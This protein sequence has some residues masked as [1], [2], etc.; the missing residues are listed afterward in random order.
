MEFEELKNKWKQL[1]EHVKAQDDKI[2]ELT[3]Q[4]IAGKV[5]SPLTVLKR[6]CVIAAVFVPFMLPFFFW[7]YSFVGLDC[8]EWQ[9]ILL[10][11]LT[12]VFVVFTFARELYF[13]FDLKK[14]NVGR[15]SAIES[16]RQT[17][18]FR[19]HY[20]YGVLIDLVIGLV[21]VMVMCCSFNREFLYG[22]M[23]GGAIGAALGYKMFKYYERTIDELESSLR[24]W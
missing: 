16:L 2:R 17:I 14:I 24:E 1:D 3:D 18:R 20:H 22:G 12:W 6:H 8:P 21:F 10:Y 15:D 4:I 5:K 19:K 11:V 7:S 9:K 23:V 13:V